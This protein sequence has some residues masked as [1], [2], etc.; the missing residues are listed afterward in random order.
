MFR[1]SKFGGEKRK[2]KLIEWQR[3][4]RQ[5]KREGDAICN[6]DVAL[7]GEEGKK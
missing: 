1:L 2:K 6:A 3:L 4:E 7:S 5:G